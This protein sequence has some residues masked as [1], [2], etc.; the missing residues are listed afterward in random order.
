MSVERVIPILKLVEKEEIT[1]TVRKDIDKDISETDRQASNN[2]KKQRRPPLNF[3][4]MNIPMGAEL[5]CPYEGTDY[6]VIVCTP[7][8]VNFNDE[9]TSLT[10]ALRKIMN[11]TWNVQPTPYFYYNGRLLSEIYNETYT[12]IDEE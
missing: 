6:K 5:L 1:A 11:I 8:K 10:A 4:E 9:E 2:L 7:R 12:N 3:V